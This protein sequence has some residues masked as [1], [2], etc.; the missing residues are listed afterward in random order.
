MCGCMVPRK[1][2]RNAKQ[3]NGERTVVFLSGG[4]KILGGQGYRSQAALVLLCAD[5]LT[6]ALSGSLAQICVYCPE[7]HVRINAET[8]GVET[9]NL[10]P[11][12]AS[13]A[14]DRRHIAVSCALLVTFLGCAEAASW[15]E[16]ID[17]TWADRWTHSTAEK[18]NGRFVAEA[19]PGLPDE[20]ALKV[21]SNSAALWEYLRSRTCMIVGQASLHPQLRASIFQ[22]HGTGLPWRGRNASS[23]F[24]RSRA[25][26]LRVCGTC[27]LHALQLRRG[28]NR[29][30]HAASNLPPQ[31]LLVRL[32][33]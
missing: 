12:L 4:F 16:S 10:A 17:S 31:S 18:Y 23:S 29:L 8:H 2:P 24:F 9:Y 21:R 14:G 33:P 28:S 26:F 20:L 32:S 27:A 6:R 1:R 30:T 5:W 13:M 25:G 22:K 11:S 15:T 7:K 19:P 3:N